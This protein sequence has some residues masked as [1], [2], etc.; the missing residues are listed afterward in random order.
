MTENLKWDD[1]G[2]SSLTLLAAF[3]GLNKKRPA[4]PLDPS[5]F[6][7]CIHL[8]E[9]LD[10]KK[11]E[12]NDLLIKVA[13]IYPEWKLFVDN[14]DAL[15]K[16]YNEEKDQDSAPKLYELMKNLRMKNI[17]KYNKDRIIEELRKRNPY[18]QEI[19]TP[20]SKEEI[21]KY[22]KILINKGFSPDK[23]HAHWMRYSWDLCVTELNGMLKEKGIQED[24]S[25]Q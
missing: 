4:V 22:I 21:K 23:I 20:L 11:N 8:L 24:D 19:F 14:W 18:P 17:Q 15:I 7:R 1:Y 2:E 13:N 9:C 6:R 5:D 12:I 10:L 16:L 25:H 3:I